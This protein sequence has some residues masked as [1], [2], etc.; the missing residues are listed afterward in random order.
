MLCN[1]LQL[2][3]I[4]DNLA[5]KDTHDLTHRAFGTQSMPDFR[6]DNCDPTKHSDGNS[7]EL[8]H[9]RL[10]RTQLQLLRTA[11]SWTGQS[12]VA[13]PHAPPEG[14]SGTETDQTPIITTISKYPPAKPGALGCEP[15]K[16]AE[17]AAGSESDRVGHLKVAH[18]RHRFIC[19]RRLS[20][21]ACCL[22]YSRITSVSRPTVDTKYSLAQKCWPT[23]FRFFSPYTRAKCIA[24][25][26][27]IN[28]IT[29]DTAYFGGIEINMCT[30]SSRR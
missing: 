27:L 14:Q 6:A 7:R 22:M 20:S 25:F 1:A 15:L 17:R 24:L 8:Q 30:W 10:L 16:A 2:I 29:C 5:L 12:T 9:A 11:S 21:S 18:R 4:G 13:R 23:K 19:S 3:V 28:P 26:P